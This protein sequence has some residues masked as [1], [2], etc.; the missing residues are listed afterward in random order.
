MSTINGSASA[1]KYK[2]D[3]YT[4]RDETPLEA[5]LEKE[6]D[7]TH[8]LLKKL[9]VSQGEGYQYQPDI[10]NAIFCGHLQADCD[11][12]AGAIAAAVL[13]KGTPAR[14]SECNAETKFALDYWKC[15][16]PAHIET[17]LRKEPDRNVCLVDFQQRSQ[18]HDS[19]QMHNIVGIIDHHAL[20]SS[21]I[22]TERP[23]FV[24][25]RPWG[26]VSTILAHSFALQEKYLPRNVAGMLLSAILSDTLNLRSPTTANWDRR[27][28]TM[29]V[30]YVGLEDVNMFAAALFRAKSRELLNMSAFALVHGD[31]KLF[32]FDSVE[33]EK[34]SIGYSVIETT[35][36]ESSLDRAD[37]II[38][39]MNTA[40]QDGNLTAMLLAVVDIVKLNSEVIICG[41]VEE[42]LA[43]TAYGGTPSGNSLSLPGCVSRK[44]D[45]IPPLARAIKQDGWTPPPNPTM[46]RRMSSI[47]MNY[48]DFTNDMPVRVYDDDE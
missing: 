10:E 19:I 45:F 46:G 16:E 43:V 28:V 3:H 26:S 11:S 8:S 38:A 25:I 15:E 42:S 24:D 17:L 37:E 35:D 48:K 44:L 6:W 5:A 27:M 29:L 23:I 20:Q 31:M 9:P 40:R 2:R 14:A 34:Y 47:V 12:I 22:I 30:Q 41:P 33:G 7:K 36:A 32:K 21:T 4:T 18:L 1:H 39:E 13:H